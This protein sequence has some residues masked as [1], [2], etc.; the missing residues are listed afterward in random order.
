[1]ATNLR[2]AAVIAML[3]MTLGWSSWL[4]NKN[5]QNSRHLT[6]MMGELTH[7]EVDSFQKTIDD[8]I[9]KPDVLGNTHQTPLKR[10]WTK[11]NSGDFRERIIDEPIADVVFEID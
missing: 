9:Y 4:E 2:F 5:S 6:I 1:M 10:T 8:L 7:V 3:S 11:I